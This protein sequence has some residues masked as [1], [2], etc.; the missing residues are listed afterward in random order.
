[1]RK[2][3]FILPFLALLLAN[4]GKDSVAFSKGYDA[5]L[6]SEL[7]TKIERRDSLSQEDYSRMIAQNEAI[8]QYLIDRTSKISELPDSCRYP[9]WRT[10]TAEPEYLE[11]FGYMFTLGSALY[12]ADINGRLDEDNAEAYAAL[13]DYNTKLADYSDRF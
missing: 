7:S 4:C 9:A 2:I 1:M 11:R 6:C 10:M 13:D 12:Q 8:L 3:L 5:D